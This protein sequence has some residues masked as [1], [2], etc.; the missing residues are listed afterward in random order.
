MMLNRGSPEFTDPTARH[1]YYWA[2]SSPQGGFDWLLCKFDTIAGEHLVS[3]FSANNYLKLPHWHLVDQLMP[4][5]HAI[6]SVAGDC[7]LDL[8]ACNMDN[9][10]LLA[11]RTNCLEHLMLR[12][13]THE[14]PSM[15]I[16]ARA[17]GLETK[18]RAITFGA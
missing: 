3:V 8:D 12:I 13:K 9:S 7:V 2:D 11:A 1:H 14:H 10:E 6:A 15:G 4:G 17:A 18:C 5:V 16:G